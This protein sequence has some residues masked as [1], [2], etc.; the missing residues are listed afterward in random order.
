MAFD[1]LLSDVE[2]IS[3]LPNVPGSTGMTPEELK[4]QFD[5]A[6]VIIKDYIN[7]VLYPEIGKSADVDEAIQNSLDSTLTSENSPAQAKAVGDIIRGLFMA[8]VHDGDYVLRFGDS[9]SCEKTGIRTLRIGSGRAVMLGNLVQMAAGE[10]ELTAAASGVKRNNLV[11]L[12]WKRKNG[13]VSVSFAA[14][15]GT[16]TSGT[17]EDPALTKEDINTSGTTTRELPLYRAVF[18]GTTLESVTPMFYHEK[19]E[20]VLQYQSVSVPV[21]AW[22]HSTDSKYGEYG[23]WADIP[24]DGVAASMVADVYF[25][26]VDSASGIL[27]PVAETHDGGVWIYANQIPAGN[28]TIPTIRVMK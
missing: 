19:V 12:R 5:R 10:V 15:A 28:I 16:E 24:L 20:S 22:N 14:I 27:S 3:K 18:N 1:K 26:W 8:A 11:V 23:C 9:F 7:D 17:P 25:N 21:S 2:F 13:E 6:A 4:R